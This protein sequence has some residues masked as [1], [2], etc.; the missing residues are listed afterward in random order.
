MGG[1]GAT[2]PFDTISRLSTTEEFFDFLGLPYDPAV[3]AVNRLHILKRFA[4]YLEAEGV[5]LAAIPWE[6]G[7][8]ALLRAYRDFV[9]GGPLDYRLFKVLKDRA[10]RA[11]APCEEVAP[12]G[13][14]ERGGCS[15]CPGWAGGGCAA[16]VARATP[17]GHRGGPDPS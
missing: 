5:D 11:A 15:G 8:D 3:V 7:R 1:L 9:T 14:G 4:Q 10:P 13:R 6:R 17:V 2:P 12:A 16:E